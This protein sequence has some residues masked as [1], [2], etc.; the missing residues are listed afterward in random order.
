MWVWTAIA[1]A[2]LLGIYDTFKKK[3][4][5][6]NGV[7]NV[8]LYTTL[9][10]TLFFVPM[11]LSSAFGWGLGDGTILETGHGTL[12]EHLLVILKAAI[13]TVSW[14]SGL[15]GLKNLPITTAS[16][17][18]ASRPVFVL[19]FSI[20]V[21]GEKL[22]GMQW[23]G[24][25]VSFLALCLLSRSSKKEGIDFRHNKWIMM[26]VLS[27]FSGVASA[28]LDKHILSWMKP[29]FV[30]SWCNL[31]ILIFMALIVLVQKLSG[32]SFYEKFRWD[33]TILYIAIF[34]T[35][36]DYLYF[37][38]LSFE[39]SML[40][41]VSLLRRSSVIVTFISGAIIFKEGNLKAKALDLFIL[42]CGMT[43]LV[44]ASH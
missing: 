9:I 25:L 40:S 42:L 28:L 2:F 15:Y 16:T 44:L 33:K 7:M 6:S 1:S 23:V 8:L 13:V 5:H 41:V 32:S 20:L 14:I 35:F 38:T 12:R 18:K 43:I 17:L 11:I 27:I 4:S 22:N 36:A 29:M 30:Q 21:F 34:L 24:V 37:Y 26:M 39:D 10:S 19:L 31:Y 3:A